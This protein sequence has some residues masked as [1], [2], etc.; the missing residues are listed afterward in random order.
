MDRSEFFSTAFRSLA[1]KC[2]DLVLD[3][4]VMEFLEPPRSGHRPP[5][6]TSPEARFQEVCTQCDRCMEACPVNCV[7]V[8]SVERRYPVIYPDETPCV[9][10]EGY[11]CIAAC[12]TGALHVNNLSQK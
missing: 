4:P 5:G 3:S 1:A 6:A 11:P 10:C 7:M 2:V 12:P 8:D 9:H